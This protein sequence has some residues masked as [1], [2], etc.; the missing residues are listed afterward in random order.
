MGYYQELTEEQKSQKKAEKE[1]LNA[2][3]KKRLKLVNIFF[4][5]ATGIFIATIILTI[6]LTWKNNVFTSKIVNINRNGNKY[7]ENLANWKLEPLK[8][9]LS[10]FPSFNVISITELSAPPR[11]A[12][13]APV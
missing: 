7:K 9:C 3:L 6:A 5:I 11:L 10:G 13:N 2:K 12:G 1:K 4:W 8:D